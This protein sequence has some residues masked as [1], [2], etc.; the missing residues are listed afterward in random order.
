MN[1]KIHIDNAADD[2][3]YFRHYKG[4]IYK[5]LGFAKDSETLQDVVI[6]QAMYGNFSLWV[7][8]KKMFFEKILVNDQLI[9]RFSMI[10][11]EEA[12]CH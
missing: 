2:I 4:G 1:D 7:R 9:Q 10:S 5:L 8:P 3:L 6:Y 12:L 11:K